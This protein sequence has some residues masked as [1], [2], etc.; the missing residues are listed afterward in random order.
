[1]RPETVRSVID[2]EW[3]ALVELELVFGLQS[4]CTSEDLSLLFDGSL[5]LPA[6]RRLRLRNA[7]FADRLFD[8]VSKSPLTGQLEF[9]DLRGGGLGH[10]AAEWQRRVLPQLQ[11]EY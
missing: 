3:P 9:L 4:E 5:E 6:L 7:R 8:M 2:G 10:Y 1:M 11:L